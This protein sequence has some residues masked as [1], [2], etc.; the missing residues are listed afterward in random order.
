[1]ERIRPWG[2]RAHRLATGTQNFSDYLDSLYVG[3]ITLGTP[4]QPFQVQLDTGSSNLW[5]VDV[6]CQID[7][8]NGQDHPLAEKSSTY[9][10][11]GTFFDIEYGTGEVSGE[12]S[13]D[14]LVVAGLTVPDQVFGRGTAVKDPFGYFPLDGI[15]GLGWPALAEDQVTPPFQDVIK[16]LDAP[17]FT[18]YHITPS[19]GQP[20]GQITYGSIDNTNCD[21]SSIVYTPI[22][23]ELYWHVDSF[24][25]GTYTNPVAASAI[26]DTGSS[27]ILA[28]T[29]DLNA[30]VEAANA[31]YNGQY[32]LYVVDCDAPKSLPDLVFTVNGQQMN[33]AATEYVV[34]LELDDGKC[35]L[36]I[37]ENFDDKDDFDWLLGDPFIRS[38]CNVYDAGGERI[39]FAEAR[40]QED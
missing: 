2:L 29:D 6:S 19:L 17:L 36:A 25:V 28:P 21:T 8:C 26:S 16:Q 40:H 30:I 10:P 24:S 22:T 1:M 11:N 39:G 15:L 31:Y 33:I 34:D 37:D 35:A 5:V 4:P 20:G 32:G 18:I 3:N 23:R 13:T 12:L 9:K 27:Y 14:T 38:H 7:Q